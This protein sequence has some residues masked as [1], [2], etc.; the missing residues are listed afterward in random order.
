[1]SVSSKT[2]SACLFYECLSLLNAQ[3]PYN[4]PNPTEKQG[5]SQP[6][7]EFIK[8]LEISCGIDGKLS[9][10]Y[11]C[12]YLFVSLTVPRKFPRELLLLWR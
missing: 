2:I 5:I 6:N 10:V 1:M 7:A 9:T 12:F 3:P 11:G 4:L 8:R